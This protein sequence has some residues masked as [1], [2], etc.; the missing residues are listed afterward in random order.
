[1][2]IPT[3]ESQVSPTGTSSMPF[4]LPGEKRSPIKVPYVEDTTLKSVA[5]V[6]NDISE[7][8]IKAENLEQFND[9][10]TFRDEKIENLKEDIKNDKTGEWA[11]LTVDEYV[12]KFK[13]RQ[14]EIDE[15]ARVFLKYADATKSFENYTRAQ[16]ITDAVEI[17]HNAWLKVNDRIRAKSDDNINKLEESAKAGNDKSLAEIQSLLDA[18]VNANIYSKEET[19]VRMKDIGKRVTESYIKTEIDKPGNAIKAYVSMISGDMKY[20]NDA[21]LETQRK[22]RKYAESE[23][24]SQN[25]GH[26]RIEREREKK[27]KKEKEKNGMELL[28]LFYNGKITKISQLDAWVKEKPVNM[29]V[30]TRIAEIFRKGGVE[31]DDLETVDMLNKAVPMASRNA[32]ELLNKALADGKIT[33]KTFKIYS[34]ALGSKEE[35]IGMKYVTDAMRFPEDSSRYNEKEV[36]EFS[37]LKAAAVKYYHELRSEGKDYMEAANMAV[38]AFSPYYNDSIEGINAKIKELGKELNQR[39]KKKETSHTRENDYRIKELKDEVE[40]L[41]RKKLWLIN[42]RSEK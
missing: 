10:K 5:N 25:V 27:L 30:Y 37:L 18:G 31:E 14:K 41:E 40:S 19:V 9:A 24:I 32:R 3:Y 34:K 26:E 36:F 13:E 33:G 4:S 1:M 17:K 39:I 12:D 21:D 35:Q 16:G 38:R 22:L 11:N 2:K 20:Y 28:S 7:K 15:Q 29:S 42:K 8:M 6:I 23:I